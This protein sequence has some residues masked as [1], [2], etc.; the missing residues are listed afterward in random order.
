MGSNFRT[1]VGCNGRNEVL[2]GGK[3]ASHNG[4]C[5]L[6]GGKVASHNGGCIVSCTWNVDLLALKEHTN[7]KGS[8]DACMGWDGM[9]WGVGSSVV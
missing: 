1:W 8:G 3:V 6:I 4:G 2:I 5:S 7:R 9:G